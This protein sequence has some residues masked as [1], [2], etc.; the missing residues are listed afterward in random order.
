MFLC[1]ICDP[2]NAA[3]NRTLELVDAEFVETVDVPS[4]CIIFKSGHPRKCRYRLDLRKFRGGTEIAG[5]RCMPGVTGRP[6]LKSVAPRHIWS[7][8]HTSANTPGIPA[9]W[10]LSMAVCSCAASSGFFAAAHSCGRG[11]EKTVPDII[12][13]L[14]LICRFH[15]APPNPTTFPS[16]SVYVTLRTPFGS[17]SCVAGFNP[18]LGYLSDEAIEVTQEEQVECVASVFRLKPYE[19]VPMFGRL[20]YCL[21]IIRQKSRWTAEQ[22]LIPG[23]AGG[24]FADRESCK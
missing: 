15:G 19:N 18:R 23:S 5:T 11:G 13:S 6:V 4:D 1:I 12:L 20:P 21:N 2:E 3:S 9:R 7:P 14:L 17:V 10:T 8:S 24:V 22:T 16:G